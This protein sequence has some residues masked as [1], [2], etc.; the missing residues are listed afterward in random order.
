M[1]SWQQ[2]NWE[3]FAR[4]F[5]TLH[6]AQIVTAPEGFGIREFCLAMSQYALCSQV[7]PGLE[8]WCGE[9]QSCRLF[10]AGSHPDFHVIGNEWEL[11]NGR[12]ETI[13]EYSRRYQDESASEKK[14]QPRKVIPI[15]HVRALIDSFV[16]RPHI[17]PRKVGLIVP[18]DRLNINA[19]NALLKLLEEPPPD[20][21]L[22]LLTSEPFRL[23]RTVLSRCV[24]ITL[25]KPSHQQALDWL[26][27]RIGEHDIELALQLTEGAPFKAR[28]MCETGMLQ[29]RKE[30]L[31]SLVGVCGRNQSLY[32]LSTRLHK[33]DFEEV[34]KWMQSFVKD[35][36]RWKTLGKSPWWHTG[37]EHSLMPEKMSDDQLFKIYD[38]LCAYR[39]IARG[40]LNEELALDNIFLSIQ[41]S[42]HYF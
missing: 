41:R 37:S 40:S 31:E 9:C 35:V 4:S 34:I 27:E 7:A 12:S 23:P 42:I 10:S 21:L 32:Q 33:L 22:I 11:V 38:R 24:Q 36:I 26:R 28:A 14:T 17:A 39:R 19:A 6:H 2:A 3:G 25:A 15:D 5:G 20:S 1:L 18:A 29:V 13:R 8:T 30:M 16:K